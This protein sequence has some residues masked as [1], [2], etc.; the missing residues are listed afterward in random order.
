MTASRKA[1]R[2]SGVG[3]LDR[4]HRVPLVEGR[5]IRGNPKNGAFCEIC[6]LESF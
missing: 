3:R 6:V 2:L 5:L 4:R 1:E